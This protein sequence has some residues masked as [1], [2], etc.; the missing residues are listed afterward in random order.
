[1]EEFSEG[2]RSAEEKS[3]VCTRF[4]QN[5]PKEVLK[6]KE[7]AVNGG[8]DE[9]TKIKSQLFGPPHHEHPMTGSLEG[10]S[11]NEDKECSRAYRRSSGRKSFIP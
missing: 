7:M 10:D 4:E 3:P 8:R 5:L 9:G 11:G 6:N 2:Q 1:M